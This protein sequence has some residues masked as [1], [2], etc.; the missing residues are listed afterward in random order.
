MSGSRPTGVR[1]HQPLSTLRRECLGQLRLILDR[2][3]PVAPP[4]H[5][6][7]NRL[8]VHVRDP[9]DRGRGSGGLGMQSLEVTACR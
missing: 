3:P 9:G 1:A 7:W 5:A 4:E 8:S 6:G 2:D